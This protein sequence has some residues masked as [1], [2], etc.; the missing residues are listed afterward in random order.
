ML[1]FAPTASFAFFGSTGSVGT[2]DAKPWSSGAIQD[3]TGLK[4]L[5][6]QL[7]PVV[8]YFD[9]LEIFADDE[10]NLKSSKEN[11]AWYRHAEI[12]HGRV[13]MAAFVG[14]LVQANGIYFPGNLAMPLVPSYAFEKQPLVTFA[15]ISAAGGP[16]D[17]WDAMP[18]AAKVQIL[19]FVGFLE[20]WG[21]SATAFEKGGTMHYVRG[22]KPGYYPPI[23]G[24]AAV[25]LNL[26]DPFGL[27]KKRSEEQKANGLLTEINNGRLAMLGIMGFVAESKVPNSVPLLGGLVKPYSGEVMAPFTASDSSLPLVDA[28]LNIHPVIGQ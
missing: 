1:A 21:E 11:L 20:L 7:N 17:Q 9:P 26:Y 12:K 16:A 2:T 15:D 28:M 3:A 13:A 25:P 27:S 22:G 24:L 8:G 5:A 6:S 23:K 18:T 4:T 14:Y 10:G 19:L